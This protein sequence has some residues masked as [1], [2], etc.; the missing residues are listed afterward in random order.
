MIIPVPCRTDAAITPVGK[1]SRT[2]Y[3]GFGSTIKK[4]QISIPDFFKE[5]ILQ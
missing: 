3:T 2:I 4:I 5:F 1:K